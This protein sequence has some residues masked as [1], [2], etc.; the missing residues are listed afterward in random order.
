MASLRYHAGR[1]VLYESPSGW[2]VRIKTKEG[3][4]DLPLM[5]ADLDE[6]ILQ[7][8]TL[9]ADARAISSSKPFCYQCIH[10]KASAAKCDLG[11]P[12]GRSSGGRFAKDCSA[13]KRDRLR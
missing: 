1:M 5:S 4:L 12:E 6:A 13:F 2:R 11:F 10:W 8:E 7:A 3:K 9:Y